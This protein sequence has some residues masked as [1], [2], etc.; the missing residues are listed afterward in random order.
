[1]WVRVDPRI[2]LDVCESDYTSVIVDVCEGDYTSVIVGVCEGDCSSVIVDVCEGG[3]TRYCGRVRERVHFP[4]R[5][6]WVGLPSIFQL[7]RGGLD[8]RPLSN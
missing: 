7:D 3:S 6:W 2:I 4:I 5:S 1:M 8:C